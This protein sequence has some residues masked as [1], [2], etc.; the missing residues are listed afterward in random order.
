MSGIEAAREALAPEQLVALDALLEVGVDP[1]RIGVDANWAWRL[2]LTVDGH[3][4]PARVALRYAAWERVA[5]GVVVLCSEGMVAVPRDGTLYLV[6]G[7]TPLSVPC[8]GLAYGDHGAC[9]RCG[10][11]QPAPPH[12]EDRLMPERKN[13]EK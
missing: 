8:C 12:C 10:V 11:K 5:R 6:S 9:V 1:A 4:V 2:M 3:I 7:P 13:K